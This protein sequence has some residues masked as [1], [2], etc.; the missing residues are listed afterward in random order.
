MKACY[1]LI[2]TR[3]LPERFT[4][5]RRSFLASRVSFLLT[6]TL[7]QPRPLCLLFLQAFLLS[8]R[9]GFPYSM[10]WGSEDVQPGPQSEGM[11][12]GWISADVLCRPSSSLSRAFAFFFSFFF[13][14]TECVCIVSFTPP[15]RFS[16]KGHLCVIYLVLRGFY[17]QRRSPAMM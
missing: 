4:P 11:D 16:E 5:A 12:S 17:E 14:S 6:P 13:R 15:S 9:S 10:E 2:H 8:V 7:V 1:S 3:A